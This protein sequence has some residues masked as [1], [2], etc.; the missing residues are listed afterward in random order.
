MSFRTR[1]EMAG[2]PV[3]DGAGCMVVAEIGPNHNG[4]IAEAFALVDAAADAG[5]DAV[6]FQYRIVE[7]ELFDRE[8]RSYYYDESRYDFV[9]RVQVFP[10]E[11]HRDLRRHAAARGMAYIC[12]AMCEEAVERIADLQPDGIKIPSGEVN[13]PWLLDR[14]ATSGYPVIA[15]SGMSAGPEIDAMMDILGGAGA[16]GADDVILLHCMS[17]YPTR[18]E[19]MHLH[20]VTGLRRRYGCLSGL[21]DHSRRREVATSVALGAA[22]I[23][24]HFTRDRD[25]SGPDHHVSLLP[26]EMV[27]LVGAVRDLEAALGGEEKILGEHAENM[28][29][30]F[31]NSIVTRRDVAVGE[32][33]GRDNL[34]LK[35][36]GTGLGPD[37]LADVLGRAAARD[38]PMDTPVS[39]EDLA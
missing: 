4:D 19:D 20:M 34:A 27:D 30:T 5:S 32:V 17:E 28:R 2:R 33:L 22:M 21:S 39:L 14:A 8:T 7:A 29:G 25:A 6:K 35:K 38:L 10:H 37:R 15:S 9:Q 36:P 24:V 11:T 13:N 12:S 18:L 16:G 3:G 26:A 31:T 1:F 23:E